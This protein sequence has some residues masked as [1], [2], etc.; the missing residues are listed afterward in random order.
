MGWPVTATAWSFTKP[1]NSSLC[2]EH[3]WKTSSLLQRF[4]WRHGYCLW[5]ARLQIYS[6]AFPVLL[7]SSSPLLWLYPPASSTAAGCLWASITPPNVKVRLTLSAVC[8]S[9]GKMAVLH[10]HGLLELKGNGSFTLSLIVSHTVI[11]W[12][13]LSLS[14]FAAFPEG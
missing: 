2:K 12:S 11:I 6:F 4:Q 14:S 10:S 7:Q 5:R 9:L 8:P 1:L 3:R 13:S